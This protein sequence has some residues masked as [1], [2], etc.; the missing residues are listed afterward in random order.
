MP[1]RDFT[2]RSGTRWRVWNTVAAG[3]GNTGGRIESWLTFE[4]G[5]ARRRLTPI[6]NGWERATDD[7]LAALCS[8]ARE[9]LTP[10]N[11]VVLRKA[12]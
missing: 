12:R 10:P 9:A 8:T 1:I 2:D 11:G 6:P 4:S 5:T 7:E 3:N